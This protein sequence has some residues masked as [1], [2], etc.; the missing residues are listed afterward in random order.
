MTAVTDTRNP[1]KT[2]KAALDLL[3]DL[4]KLDIADQVSEAVVARVNT[5]I[6]RRGGNQWSEEPCN[7]SGGITNYMCS[8][9]VNPNGI[10]SSKSS[11]DAI[12][13]GGYRKHELSRKYGEILFEFL[14]EF[15]DGEDD[16]TCFSILLVN[17]IFAGELTNSS[18]CTACVLV[19]AFCR[20]IGKGVFSTHT[21][22]ARYSG[23]SNICANVL[24][25]LKYIA[26]GEAEISTANLLALCEG[27]VGYYT[28]NIKS[29][30][31]DVCVSWLKNSLPTVISNL[32]R[33][34]TT[35]KKWTEFEYDR[36][37][38]AG[39]FSYGFMLGKAWDS[40][41][42]EGQ[43]KLSD[44]LNK[45]AGTATSHGILWSLLKCINPDAEPI[46]DNE[47]PQQV[48][49]AAEAK[50]AEAVSETLP[51]TLSTSQSTPKTRSDV[52]VASTT[53]QF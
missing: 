39:P 40:G 43:K 1:P 29:D 21:S 28:R 32:R 20:A 27:T 17:L 33:M 30:D 50:K 49:L 34:N 45:L 24:Y 3:A 42:Y 38:Y 14:L 12:L 8:W 46:V 36:G 37:T 52:S 51:G 13:P 44:V 11:T 19:S 25:H 2:L 10:P 26:P 6:N 4:Y 5:A 53:A 47:Q 41:R 35:C 23:L 18:T 16:A 7:G 48:T 31:F 9:L 15:V 22:E